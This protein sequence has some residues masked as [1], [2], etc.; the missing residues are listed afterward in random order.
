[1]YIMTDSVYYM[2]DISAVRTINYI[3]CNLLTDGSTTLW[4]TENAILY[5][6]AQ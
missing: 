6:F 1:M 3:R 2:T 5:A 4:D